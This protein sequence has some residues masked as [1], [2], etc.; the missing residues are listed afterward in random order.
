MPNILSSVRGI[1]GAVLWG[2]VV[3][4]PRTAAAQ[5]SDAAFHMIDRMLVASTYAEQALGAFAAG[6]LGDVPIRTITRLPLSGCALNW[7]QLSAWEAWPGT[8]TPGRAKVAAVADSI[9]PL[10]GVSF[11]DLPGLVDALLRAVPNGG[12]LPTVACLTETIS[13]VLTNPIRDFA[14]TGIPRGQGLPPE[15]RAGVRALL[16]PDWPRNRI[17]N[18]DGNSIVVFTTFFGLI[19]SDTPSFVPMAIALT[20][21]PDLRL[22]AWATR[23]GP[24]I[25]N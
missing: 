8:G 10:V 2:G 15:L 20:F 25:P 1:A 19:G 13:Q 4:A 3:L 9:Y 12:P 21:G 22:N 16:P 6:A 14:D 18:I 23:V 17:E 5:G 7:G 11:S 24:S